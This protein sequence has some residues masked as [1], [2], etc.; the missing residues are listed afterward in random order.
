[1]VE[2]ERSQVLKAISTGTNAALLQDLARILE[3]KGFPI[4]AGSARE[5][6]NY[7]EQ[8]LIAP[9]KGKVAKDGLDVGIPWKER[10]AILKVLLKSADAEAILK[11]ANMA[12]ANNWPVAYDKLQ[13]KASNLLGQVALDRAI[14]KSAAVAQAAKV[15][16]QSKTSSPAGTSAKP[17]SGPNSELA[18]AFTYAV[19]PGDSPAKIALAYTGNSSVS[20]LLK[21]NPSMAKRLAK[22]IVYANKDVLTLPRS[23]VTS[24]GKPVHGATAAPTPATP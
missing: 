6:A 21:V 8:G 13:I 12:K 3:K 20:E 5:R 22:G 17:A 1:M 15:D 24:D 11:L 7:L 19:K 16:R 10:Q 4:A 23:W 18:S 14:E 9:R 2:P